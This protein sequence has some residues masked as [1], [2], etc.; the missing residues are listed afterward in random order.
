[1]QASRRKLTPAVMQ[2]PVR[3]RPDGISLV[4]IAP[5]PT[6]VEVQGRK[7]PVMGLSA[8]HVARL[9]EGFPAIRQMMVEQ[10][11][12]PADWAKAM[13]GLVPIVIAAGLGLDD[14]PAEIEAAGKLGLEDQLSFFIPIWK[15]TMPSGIGPFFQRLTEIMGIPLPVPNQSPSG[16]HTKAQ[17]T[18]SPRRSKR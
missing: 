8:E 12:S 18:K 16:G 11:V 9:I 5:V 6:I 17:V 4:D 2:P 13:P 1:M 7:Y 14:D 15:K 10:K 3:K